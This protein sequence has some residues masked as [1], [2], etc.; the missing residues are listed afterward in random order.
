MSDVLLET[1]NLSASYPGKPPALEAVTF[2]GRAGEAIGV[3][4]PNGSGKTTLL[5]AVLGQLE[6]SGTV[7]APSEIAYVPQSDHTQLDFPVSAFDVAL[8]GAYQRTPWYRRTS[9]VD[10]Q[11]A[12]DALGRVGLSGEADSQFGELSGGQRQRALIARALVQDAQLLL[13][14]EP[15][16]AV[17]VASERKIMEI[18][19]ELRGEQRCTLITTH[20]IE[21]TLRWDRVL[22]LNSQQ[23]AFGPPK[24]TL[25]E[26]VLADTYGSEI[27]TLAG[28]TKAIAVQHH[29]HHH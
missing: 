3:L 6:R 16:A 13:L 2:Q 7:S 11:L 8:M 22:C 9:R 21:Q 14:D 4:G 19:N 1:K 10:R 12:K 28:G 27:V 20:D 29:D 15:F 5:K 25:T 17:D 26:S 23:I 24:E 18:L